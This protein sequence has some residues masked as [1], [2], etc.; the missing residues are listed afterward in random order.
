MYVHS[1]EL[2]NYKSIGDTDATIILEPNI[3]AIIGMNESGKSNVLEG[4]LHI[5][6]LKRDSHA[7]SSDAANRNI[8]DAAIKYKII[9]KP[10]MDDCEITE[11][12]IEI[13][14]DAYKLT[15]GLFTYY[16][17]T[18]KSTFESMLK[19]PDRRQRNLS[20]TRKAQKN[21]AWG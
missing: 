20:V 11:T 12:K 8:Y 5:N 16:A 2:I 1:V 9:L 13:S 15:G 19:R 14:R 21:T 10:G 7:F 18:A 17:A 6:F 4:L 3:T